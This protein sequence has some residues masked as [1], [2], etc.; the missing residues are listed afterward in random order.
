MMHARPRQRLCRPKFEPIRP[1]DEYAVEL[2]HGA[3]LFASMMLKYDLAW[4][5]AIKFVFSGF[6]ILERLVAAYHAAARSGGDMNSGPIG[7][8][9][10]S[11]STRSISVM[12]ALSMRQPST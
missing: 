10:V 9:I 12:V 5:G 2:T 8:L 1:H 7:S 4:C 11:L 3:R 6:T